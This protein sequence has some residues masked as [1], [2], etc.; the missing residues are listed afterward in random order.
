MRDLDPIEQAFRDLVEARGIPT[1][2]HEPVKLPY[3]LPVATLLPLGPR[4]VVSNTGGATDASWRWR[5]TV[6]ASLG[7]ARKAQR[8]L[9]DAAVLLLEVVRDSPDL[10]GTCE[11]ARIESSGDEPNFDFEGG[12]VWSEFVLEADTEETPSAP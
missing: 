1:V 7:D 8:E 3:R 10:E 6:Y 11:R 2:D 5:V 12:V 9:R 4:D